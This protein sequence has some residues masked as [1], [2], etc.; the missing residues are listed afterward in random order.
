MFKHVKRKNYTE[1]NY[2]IRQTYRIFDYESI[3]I[4]I[5]FVQFIVFELS[6][7]KHSN[8]FPMGHF[9]IENSWACSNADNFKMIK[10]TNLI[11]V[12]IDS[13]SQNL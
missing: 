7:F 12:S 13:E 4:M 6:A 8:V 1:I 10:R 11:M 3:D 9:P 5:K 2:E